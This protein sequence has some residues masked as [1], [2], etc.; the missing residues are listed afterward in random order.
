MSINMADVKQIMYGNKEVIKIED[1]LGNILWQKQVGPTVDPYLFYIYGTT[2]YKLDMVNKIATACTRSGTNNIGNGNKI[3]AVG[4]HLYGLSGN[5]HQ[6]VTVNANTNTITFG[7]NLSI[8]PK[9][10]NMDGNMVAYT[11]ITNN[12][13]H[14]KQSYYYNLTE[15]GYSSFTPSGVYIAGNTILKLGSNMP[16]GFKDVYIGY[17]QNQIASDRAIMYYWSGDSWLRKLDLPMT[18]NWYTWALWCTDDRLFYDYG[19]T[20]YEFDFNTHTWKS[21][22]WTNAPQFTGARVFKWNDRYFMLGGTSTSTSMYEID[23]DTNTFTLYWTL[24]TAMRGDCLIDSK[25]RVGAG[26]NCAPRLA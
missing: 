6:T 9:N 7:S 8:W 13:S 26:Q 18:T 15:S 19:T 11:T 23:L 12:S 2:L 20:H 17:S 24:P 10:S 25:G 21:H 22:T 4:S 5:Y 1:S 16:S 3:F 14:W